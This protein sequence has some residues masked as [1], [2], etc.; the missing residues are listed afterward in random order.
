L[1]LVRH[2]LP[3]L[4][5]ARLHQHRQQVA[6]VPAL[7]SPL[8]DNRGDDFVYSPPCSLESLVRCRR[9]P[10]RQR[11]ERV[12]QTVVQITPDDG[13]RSADGIRFLAHVLAEKRPAGDGE[14]QP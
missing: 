6:M 12:L 9:H 7:L 3:G 5:V 10:K 14:C 8:L 2:G 13:E 4:L 11:G 1:L